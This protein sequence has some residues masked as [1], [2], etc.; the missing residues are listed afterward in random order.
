MKEG[1]IFENL[2]DG[3]EYI[4]KGIVNKM[5][6]LQSTKGDKLILTGVDTLQVKSFYRKI[7]EQV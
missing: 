2:L 3:M 5:V 7:I 4:V 1:D 6:F